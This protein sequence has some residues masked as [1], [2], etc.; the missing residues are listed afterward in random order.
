MMT[1][2]G[3]S[4]R[5]SSVRTIPVPTTQSLAMTQFAQSSS[6][7]K[8][9]TR[10]HSNHTSGSPIEYVLSSAEITCMK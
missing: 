2:S 10:V 6:P 7:K 5:R 9:S 1:A 8:R 4:D 3:A